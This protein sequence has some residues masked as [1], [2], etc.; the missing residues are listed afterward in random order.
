MDIIKALELSK[1]LAVEAGKAIM[2]IYNND[3]Y[4][5]YKDNSSPLTKADKT[6]NGIILDGL[7]NV[8]IDSN[9]AYLSEEEKD[10][11]SRMDKDY[12]FIIDPLD[13]TKEFVKKNGEFTVNIALVFKGNPVMGVIYAPYLKEL[14]YAAEGYGCFYKKNEK[15]RKLKVTDKTKNLLLVGSK[16]HRSEK[17]DILI[18]NNKDKISD[19]VS[20]GSS[21]KGCM[22]AKGKADIYYRF[23]LTCEWD[24]CAMQCIAEQSGAIFMQMDKTPM[25]YNRE[26]TL[27]EKGFFIVNNKEN[28]F[29]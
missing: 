26:N 8:F 20:C 27:N 29:V 5:E 24:T 11:K 10:D 19:L 3:F 7:K 22:V 6:A 16:S 28:I 23:G 1:T 18:E 13:G 2:E 17:L 21:L 4:V 14:Y 25:K 12:C 15:E 9:V